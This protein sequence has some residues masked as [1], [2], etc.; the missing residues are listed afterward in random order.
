MHQLLTHFKFEADHINRNGL[1]NRDGN[2]RDAAGRNGQNKGLI[3]TNTTGLIGVMYKPE[4]RA[5]K[6]C[7]YARLN[8]VPKTIGYFD[9]K[10]TAA[11]VR[12]RA[13]LKDR[14]DFAVLN[15][16]NRRKEYEKYLASN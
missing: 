7:A 5:R 11:I 2:L 12:D 16:P 4:R 8:G 10:I 1:D 13:V 9:D 3:A 15:F 6:W 14:G